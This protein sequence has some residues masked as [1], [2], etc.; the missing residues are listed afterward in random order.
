MLPKIKDTV[1]FSKEFINKVKS[2]TSSSWKFYIENYGN[3]EFKITHIE[4]TKIGDFRIVFEEKE[5]KDSGEVRLDKNGHSVIGQFSGVSVFVLVG[6]DEY[7]QSNSYCNCDNPKVKPVHFGTFSY[8]YCSNCKK[9]K[10]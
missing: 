8:N 1:K 10:M 7:K 2:S 9:E 5:N 4:A 3:C 6:A